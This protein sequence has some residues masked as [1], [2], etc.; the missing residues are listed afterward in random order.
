MYVFHSADLTVRLTNAI[1]VVLLNIIQVLIFNTISENFP[2][3]MQSDQGSKE[4]A[5]QFESILTGIGVSCINSCLKCSVLIGSRYVC[6]TDVQVA[7]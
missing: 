5:D 3:A 6:T 1:V 2:S 4:F 7:G